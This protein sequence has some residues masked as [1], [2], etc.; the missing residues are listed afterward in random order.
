MFAYPQLRPQTTSIA[1]GLEQ[2]G[3]GAEDL[4][5][6]LAERQAAEDVQKAVTR[7]PDGS[8]NVTTPATSFIMGRAGHAYENAVTQ[9]LL[10]AHQTQMSSDLQGLA[11]DHIGDPAGFQKA[12][13]D[14]VD[15]RRANNPGVLG[16][17]ILQDGNRLAGQ[18]HA[19]LVNQK[20][21]LDVENA[22]Q[23]ITAQIED[24][25]NQLIALA[26]QNG[27]NTP[28]FV[29]GQNELNG[30][31][32]GLGTNPLFK[33]SPEKIAIEKKQ[34]TAL[35][36]AEAV[37]GH[38][39]Q[40]YTRQSKAAAQA[41][42]QAIY[43]NPDLP[44]VERQRLGNLA[45]RHLLYLTDED[46]AQTAGLRASAAVM[47]DKLARGI[48][49]LEQAISMLRD[50]L[51]AT[52]NLTEAK[53]LDA[54]RTIRP[55]TAIANGVTPN[56]NVTTR[57]GSSYAIPV[58]TG[59]SNTTADMIKHFEGFRAAPYP[60][61]DAQGNF[62]GYRVGYGSDTITRADGTV[63]KTQPGMTISQA[64]ADRDLQRRTADLQSTM[65]GQI[66]AGA[67]SKL[68]DKAQAAMT[69]VAYNYGHL[70]NQVVTAA[71]SGD[72]AAVAAAIAGLPANPGRRR[73]EA[74][75][76]LGYAI[77]AGSTF[78][79]KTLVMPKSANGVPFTAQQ[80]HDNPYLMDAYV[81][82][83]ARDSDA[84]IGAAKTLGEGLYQ[85]VKRGDDPDPMNL[86]N[87]Y[88]LTAAHP[89]FQ[90]QVD[91]IEMQ[92]QANDVAR[93]APGGPGGTVALG[94]IGQAKA[95]AQG[96]SIQQSEY[97]AVL[98]E[99][100][101]RQ[102]K[103]LASDPTG[104]AVAAKWIPRAPIPLDPGNA[105]N[106]TQGIL[107]R[108]TAGAQ[109]GQ[110]LGQAPETQMFDMFDKRGMASF[111]QSS[112]GQG[113]ANLLHGLVGQ[114][115]PAELD[116]LMQSKDMTG[117]ILGLVRSG[118]VA[119]MSAAFAAMDALQRQNDLAFKKDF[120]ESA[121]KDLF[122]WQHKLAFETP[123]QIAKD[124]QR[125]NDPTRHAADEKMDKLAEAG[126]LKGLTGAAVLK[127]FSGW[128]SP[129][130]A[131]MSEAP[132]QM[133]MALRDDYAMLFKDS[134]RD[135]GDATLADQY[136][137]QE[138]QKKW[139][140]SPSNGGRLMSYPP[141]RYYPQVAGSHDYLAKQLDADVV[142]LA[143][144]QG[145]KLAAPLI[146]LG[147]YD[148]GT[149]VGGTMASEDRTPAQFQAGQIARGDRVLVPDEKT[150]ADIANRLAPSYMVVVQAPDGFFHTLTMHDGVTPFRW[151]GDSAAAQ[152]EAVARATQAR[153]GMQGERDTMAARAGERQEFIARQSGAAP[154]TIEAR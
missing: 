68:G 44:E 124:I 62:A 93:N 12:A 49:V 67:W 148:I 22:H 129:A 18:F 29:K 144:D 154:D 73:Q 108:R 133:A 38:I 14:Y 122:L 153:A 64:D 51:L 55:A 140:V 61:H 114:L 143:G 10:A 94:T 126:P 24:H 99:S 125:Q 75:S 112:G 26:R 78:E 92:L 118:D 6:P 107:E 66:G 115:T 142:K 91:R 72:P 15:Q 98:A 27:T 33:M 145:I 84:Q 139:G 32:D 127:K 86:A 110:R 88:Q 31:Y 101:D 11:K 54:F 71:Q 150:Q 5:V 48:P 13:G 45:Q 65:Q 135:H 96:G 85:Q 79:G 95:M 28:D 134:F 42:A 20:A 7:N 136:A 23:A 30:L 40:T 60:D 21:A 17:A 81:N 41:E 113:A 100:F 116:A 35:F 2:L 77:P 82:A 63:V 39:D 4:A 9:G 130:G 74:A 106:F 103:F 57:L 58:D 50:E 47:V 34:A 147:G 111:L 119:K 8:L 128:F 46:K 43:N 1:P 76:I 123:E 105:D 25:K 146:P 131:P 132:A 138:L 109:I 90:P 104:Y 69:S 120:G 52:N 87:L 80:F 97:A 56:A 59:V 137:M 149:A 152:G 53:Q 141:E 37:V 70:P 83:L 102:R 19:G 151:H 89:E 3:K 117:A 36:T 16:E 121:S